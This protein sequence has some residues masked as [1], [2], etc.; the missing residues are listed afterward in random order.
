MIADA[1]LP[2]IRPNFREEFQSEYGI[3]IN[4]MQIISSVAALSM[5]CSPPQNRPRRS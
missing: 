3:L 2:A 4:I 1:C 5:C